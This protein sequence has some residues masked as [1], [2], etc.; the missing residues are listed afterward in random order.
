WYFADRNEPVAN[1][2]ERM[3]A[4]P[5]AEQPG[6]KFVY[7]YSTDILGVLVEKVSGKTLDAF[8]NERLIGPLGMRDTSFYL[9][10]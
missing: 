8:L 3:A 5:M 2:V 6:T 7:G 4:L 1:V 9:P 10:P